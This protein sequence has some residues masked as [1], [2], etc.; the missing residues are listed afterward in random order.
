VELRSCSHSLRLLEALPLPREQSSWQDIVDFKADLHDKQWEFRR[1]LNKLATENRSEA[2]ARDEIE[3]LLNEYA[4]AIE[5]H[6]IQASSSF[7][8]VFVISPL[9]IIEN[10]MKFQLVKD[11]QGRPS[12]TKTESRTN[13]SRDESPRQGMRLCVRCT[14]AVLE[15][16]GRGLYPCIAILTLY[17]CQRAPPERAS[18]PPNTA[19]PSE[20]E[21]FDLRTKCAALG[22][23]IMEGNI[24]GNALAQDALSRYNPD[25][26]RCYVKLS[27]YS[28]DFTTRLED[29]ISYEYLYDSQTHELLAQ[30]SLDHGKRS[31]SIMSDSLKSFVHDPVI[32]T[33]EETA[34]LSSRSMAEERKP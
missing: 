6:R 15:M 30:A 31:A 23:K 13:G 2:E 29:R 28:A 33:W 14:E 5:I 22:E 18:A 1:F 32:P 17:S 3:W 27:V 25:N 20:T 12:G 34:V 10:L 16:N 8:D 7:L 19:P 24:I 4:K 26:N 9:E 21:I 11:R